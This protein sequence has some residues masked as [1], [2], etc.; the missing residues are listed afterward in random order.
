MQQRN[1]RLSDRVGERRCDQLS[2]WLDRP[3]GIM[4]GTDRCG[5][6]DGVTMGVLLLEAGDSHV[7]DPT[8]LV[9]PGGADGF[10]GEHV[11]GQQVFR[12]GAWATSPVM[13][14]AASPPDHRSR[15][16][17]CSPPNDWPVPTSVASSS[18]VAAPVWF[19]LS[20]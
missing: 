19:P 1:E 13:S 20:S 18:S 6:V 16:T 7:V 9:H 10:G 12:P 2:E 8:Q 5:D 11:L 3:E 14:A 4:G 15:S 17:A